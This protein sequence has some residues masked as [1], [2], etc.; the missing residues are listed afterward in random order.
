[1]SKNVLNIKGATVLSR[2]E[3][4]SLNGG[5]GVDLTLCGCDCAGSVTGPSYCEFFFGCLQVYTCGDE[6]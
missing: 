6:S 5:I 4:K 2:N 1:M 3:Q